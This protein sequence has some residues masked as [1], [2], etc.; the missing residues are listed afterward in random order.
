MF[1]YF[2]PLATEK[3]IATYYVML[4]AVRQGETRVTL[5]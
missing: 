3:A 5:C 4:L 2:K 1:I